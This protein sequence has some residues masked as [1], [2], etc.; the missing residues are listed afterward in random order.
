[1][2]KKGR[3]MNENQEQRRKEVFLPGDEIASGGG[4]KAG[5][6]TYRKGDKIYASQIGM[7]SIRSNFV[8]IISLGG[9]YMP[10]VGDQVVGY[11]TDVGPTY[12]MVDINAPYPAPLHVNETPWKVDFGDT[13]KYLNVRDAIIAVVSQVDE[14][15]HLSVSMK[16]HGH[17]RLNTGSIYEMPPSK[18]P[19]VIGKGGSMISLIKSMA[20]CRMFVGQNGRIWIDGDDPSIE[21]VLSTLSMIEREAHQSGL[22]EKVKKFLEENAPPMPEQ[23]GGQEEAEDEAEKETNIEG[24]DNHSDHPDDEEE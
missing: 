16:E 17:R 24:G 3:I 19:R 8:N 22:T 1:M 18:V 10:R 14:I 15:K 13:G 23:T 9:K 6:G 5:S 21:V 12:W 20:N 2:K 4:L 7:K 11:I